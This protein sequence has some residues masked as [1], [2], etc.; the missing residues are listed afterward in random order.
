MNLSRIHKV[1]HEKL[2]SHRFC[3]F[4]T[5]T[6][7][8]AKKKAFYL[9]KKNLKVDGWAKYSFPEMKFSCHSLCKSYR[10]SNVDSDDNYDKITFQDHLLLSIFF[11]LLSPLYRIYFCIWLCRK[12]FSKIFGQE[13]YDF[14]LHLKSW[15]H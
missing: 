6:S 4:L 15:Q 5:P 12:T 2:R 13:C 9:M 1:V 14:L 8:S 11:S 10:R 7:E 3:C